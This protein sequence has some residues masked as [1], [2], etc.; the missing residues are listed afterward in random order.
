[1]TVPVSTSNAANSV[2]VPFLSLCGEDAG[3]L[4]EGSTHAVWLHDHM[5]ML[6]VQWCVSSLI[7]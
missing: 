7:D 1:M 2:V 5:Q 4:Y 6:T 3:Q